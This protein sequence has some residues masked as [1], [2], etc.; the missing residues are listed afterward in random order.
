MCAG[1]KCTGGINVFAGVREMTVL[2]RSGRFEAQSDLG[3]AMGVGWAASV[4]VT[5]C[6]VAFAEDAGAV[7]ARSSSK[8]QPA[9]PICNCK[10]VW[11]HAS[12]HAMAFSRQMTLRL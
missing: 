8:G 6:D 10:K 5:K 9:R 1:Y 11:V 4:A 7:F 12:S 2:G 3:H